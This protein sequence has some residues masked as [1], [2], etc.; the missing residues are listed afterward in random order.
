MVL[1]LLF[2]LETSVPNFARVQNSID[3]NAKLKVKPCV[4]TNIVLFL[5]FINII[6]LLGLI[7]KSSSF[8]IFGFLY[9][10][11]KSKRH[12]NTRTKFA[13]VI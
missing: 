9:H 2:I 1:K 3:L 12:G 7:Y 6:S 11:L 13:N 10:R 5:Q 4:F 8:Q